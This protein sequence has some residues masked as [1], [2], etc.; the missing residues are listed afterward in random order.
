MLDYLLFVSAVRMLLTT[1]REWGAAKHRQMVFG[2]STKEGSAT[3]TV[4]LGMTGIVR[5]A[6]VF[7]L[8][9]ELKSHG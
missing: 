1:F 9:L 4:P 6:S 3:D 8:A 5:L 2:T 7:V